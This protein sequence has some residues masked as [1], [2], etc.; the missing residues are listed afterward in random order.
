MWGRGGGRGGAGGEGET[1]FRIS[2]GGGVCGVETL[3]QFWKWGKIN[4]TDVRRERIPFLWSTVREKRLAE[5]VSFNVG[6]VNQRFEFWCGH[7]EPKVLV[8]MWAMWTKGLSFNVG[9]VN[10]RFEFWCGHCEPKVWVLMWALWTKGLSFDVDI[11]NQR[12]EF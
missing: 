11:V 4:V 5:G 10:Q 12:F 8:L 3:M 7:C 2:Y 6:I 1:E 9:I